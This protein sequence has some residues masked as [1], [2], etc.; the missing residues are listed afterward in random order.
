MKQPKNNKWD[1]VGKMI[2]EFSKSAGMSVKQLSEAMSKQ[3]TSQ[4]P[5]NKS[6][7]HH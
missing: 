1:E 4:F 2:S 6:K 5:E 3:K 7:F